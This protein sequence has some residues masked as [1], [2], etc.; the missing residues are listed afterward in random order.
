LTHNKGFPYYGYMNVTLTL[1][2]DLV[3]QVRKIAV[4]RDTTLTGMV[5]EYLEQVA[6]EQDTERVRRDVERLNQTFERFKGRLNYEKRTWR[7]ED[8]YDRKSR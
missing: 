8:L 2:D 5:R 1:D 7:R 6:R 3:K 4:D